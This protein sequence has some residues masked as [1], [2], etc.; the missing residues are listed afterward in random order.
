M[1]PLSPLRSGQ[2][3]CKAWQIPFRLNKLVVVLSKWYLA[4]LMGNRIENKCGLYFWKVTLLMEEVI[5]KFR[6]WGKEIYL[7]S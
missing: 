1:A 7:V 3:L 5:E 4:N 2:Y 6:F